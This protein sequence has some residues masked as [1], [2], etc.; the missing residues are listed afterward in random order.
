MR[1]RQTLF[2]AYCDAWLKRD[3][4]R[5]GDFFADHVVYIESDGSRYEG[6]NAVRDWFSGWMLHGDVLLWRVH[7]YT[8]QG[9]VMIAEWTFRCRYNDT[10]SLFDGV[11]VMDFDNDG[12]IIRLREYAGKLP[13]NSASTVTQL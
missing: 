10:E 8:H 2:R 13:G 5:L 4:S 6:L 3:G 11:S 1:E 12:K 7:R 9:R